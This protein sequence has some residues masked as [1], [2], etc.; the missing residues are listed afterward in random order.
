M[1]DLPNLSAEMRRA[2]LRQ[3][4]I[5]W[6]SFMEGK[7]SKEILALQRRTL[8][9]S[10]SPLSIADWSKQLISR[11]LHISHAQWI[12]C[13]VSLHD[14]REGYLRAKKREQILVEINRLSCVDPAS[15]P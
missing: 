2:A 14:R 8:L 11:I 7:V 13:N 4:L 6:T 5:P 1:A 12:F 3:D 10:P 9:H 15:L